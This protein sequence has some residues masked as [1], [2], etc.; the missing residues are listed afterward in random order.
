[1]PRYSSFLQ[2]LL[3]TQ[4]ACKCT[5]IC[6]MEPF[7]SMIIHL[8]RQIK[9]HPINKYVEPL[10]LQARWLSP[11]LF[12][13]NYPPSKWQQLSPLEN[14]LSREH[15]L[16]NIQIDSPLSYRQAA[17]KVPAKQKLSNQ[18]PMLCLFRWRITKRQLLMVDA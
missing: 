6:S 5:V 8:A 15:L 2:S 13:R 12:P 14:L 18:N 10:L 1:V 11:P 9:P 3:V 7:I 16:R 17:S 4:P